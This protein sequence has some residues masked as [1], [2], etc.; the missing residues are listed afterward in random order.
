M[1]VYERRKKPRT[2]DGLNGSA[3]IEIRH[4]FGPVRKSVYKV[5][6]FNEHGTSFLMPASDGYFRT[7]HPLEF[8]LVTPDLAKLESFGVVRY[9]TPFNDELGNSYFKVGL[10]NKHVSGRPNPESLRIRPK[11]LNLAGL[12]STH[13]IYFILED[14]EYEL[15]LVD[16]SRYAAAFFCSEDDKFRLAVSNALD[17]V[18][19]T[20]AGKTIF[21][22][23]VVIT[24]RTAE[25]DKYRIVIEPRSAVFDIDAIEEQERFNSV[26]RSVDTLL[27]STKKQASISTDFKARVADMRIYLE[28]FREILDSPLAA[29]PSTESDRIAF[30][31]ELSAV[32]NPK[33]DEYW[34][35]LEQQ[36][37]ALNLDDTL[38]SLYKSYLQGHIHPLILSAP[39]CHRIFFKPLG[40]PGDFEM[41]RMIC[42]NKY[43]GSTLFA[44]LIHAHA[45]RNPM[46]LANRNRIQYLSDKI[47]AFVEKHP[48]EEVRILS[49]ASGPALEIQH[50]IETNPQVADRI[51]LTLLDQE[52]E[53]LRYSQ[54][55]IYMKRIL[56]NCSIR[57][58]LIHR[59]VGAFLKQIARGRGDFPTFDLIYIFGLFDYFDDR[60]CA[61]CINKS[62]ALLN[63]RGQILVSNYS[64]DGHSHRTFMEY[65]FEWFMVY[66]DREQM[67]KL[68]E[69]T[70]KPCT[71]A[72][73]EEALGVI[74]FLALDF[75]VTS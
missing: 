45:L 18:E 2:S 34:A 29:K 71:I 35:A 23:T 1:S 49:I 13:I 32:F 52:I 27:Q 55:S 57:V 14:R 21:E 41:M 58:E 33:F 5:L 75:G 8:S 7:G 38:H 24:R 70:E 74:K 36:I 9:F 3:F 73:E 28:G 46:A 72:V 30:L 17:G 22:G 53:A 50:L 42:E 54:D 64:L 51:R 44:K 66:R 11:R 65:A 26:A 56:N 16:I 15:P 4:T 61:F 31:D 6:E 59:S 20:S 37:V 12:S 47:T 68:G 40:Y 69:M 60:T 10:E 43:D 25:A 19:I 67:R 48:D 63:E 62:A 39:I